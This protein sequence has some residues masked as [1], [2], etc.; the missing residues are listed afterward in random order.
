MVL[1][2]VLIQRALI[3]IPSITRTPILPS[4]QMNLLHVSFHVARLFYLRS[5]DFALQEL[6]ELHNL[7]P[8]ES[9]SINDVSKGIVI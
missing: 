1:G 5:T 8:H 2:Y 9:I 6:I 7:S 3:V 4:L